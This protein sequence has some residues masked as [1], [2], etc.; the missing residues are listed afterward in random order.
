MARV[1]RYRVRDAAEIAWLRHAYVESSASILDIC[2]KFDMGQ[3]ELYTL[4]DRQG[5]PMRGGGSKAHKLATLTKAPPRPRT[6]RQVLLD[7]RAEDSQRNAFLYGD[8]LGDVTLLRNRGFVVN[9][10]PA[11]RGIVVGNMI[12]TADDVRAKADRE[13]RLTAQPW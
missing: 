5:W 11:G 1:S 13:R 10:D 9:R 6:S 8:L 3:Y 2:R 12:C 7:Q 4:I